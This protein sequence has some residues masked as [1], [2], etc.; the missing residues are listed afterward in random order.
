MMRNDERLELILS[1]LNN[2]LNNE[3]KIQV[4]NLMRT[5][6]EFLA[7]FKEEWVLHKQMQQ[8]KMNME[9][10]VKAR[11]LQN[12]YMQSKNND[13]NVDNFKKFLMQMAFN[14]VIPA[15]VMPYFNN[16]KRRWV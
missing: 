11:I 4:Y 7:L 9:P 10:D 5:D 6:H 14:M 12:I 8:Y 15:P 3:Q 16:I 13:I 1:Y 2:Q